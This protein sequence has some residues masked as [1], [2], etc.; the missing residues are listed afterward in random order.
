MKVSKVLPS[1]LFFL[2]HCAG[3]A[4]LDAL[5]LLVGDSESFECSS[6]IT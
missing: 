3:G 1:E 6:L 2:A 4:L 5:S